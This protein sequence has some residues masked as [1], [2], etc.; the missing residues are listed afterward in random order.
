MLTLPERI[1][2]KMSSLNFPGFDILEEKND[3]AEQGALYFSYEAFA[4]V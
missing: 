1:Y 2:A 4:M 3:G